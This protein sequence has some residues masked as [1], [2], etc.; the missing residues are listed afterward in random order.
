MPWGLTDDKSTL[1]QV[2]AWCHQATSHYLSQCWPSSMSP[3]GINRQQ[4]VNVHQ[5][6]CVCLVLSKPWNVIYHY[7][8]ILHTAL[9][10]WKCGLIVSK[11]NIKLNL[12]CR[13]GIMLLDTFTLIF[14]YN[15]SMN[16]Q[17]LIHLP[18]AP[19]MP[20]WNGLSLVQ[21][22]ACPLIGTKPLPESMLTYCISW[23]L[24]NKLQWNSNE[25]TQFFIYKKTFE[26]VFCEMAVILSGGDELTSDAGMHLWTSSS[27]V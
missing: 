8:L 7:S 1:V 10:T 9:I 27:L 5:S 2:M 15:G 13:C 18:L 25:N 24:R 14:S 12:H 16:T 17:S 19:H 4:C 20:Q 3:Y 21:A 26:Y 22:M 6:L 23:T 11:H